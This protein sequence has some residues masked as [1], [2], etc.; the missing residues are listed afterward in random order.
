MVNLSSSWEAKRSEIT[1]TVCGKSL[2]LQSNRLQSL[3]S[4]LNTLALLLSQTDHVH[5]SNFVFHMGLF[6]FFFWLSVTVHS[7]QKMFSPCT[8]NV[9]FK[10]NTQTCLPRR[11]Y[12]CPSDMKTGPFFFL[13]LSLCTSLY[14]FFKTYFGLR[15]I[16]NSK[17]TIEKI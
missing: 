4:I 17:K 12:L 3:L 7:F 6:F 10:W 8:E 15:S 13:L 16:L 5:I 1:N 2:K 11:N 14:K 9:V